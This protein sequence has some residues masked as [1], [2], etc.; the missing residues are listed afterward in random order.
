MGSSKDRLHPGFNL[1]AKY[2]FEIIDRKMIPWGS[3]EK[4]YIMLI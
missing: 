4:I 3:V 1:Y 2:G